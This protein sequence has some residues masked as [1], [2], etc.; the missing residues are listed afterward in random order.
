MRI[1]IGHIKSR[2]DL[3][4]VSMKDNSKTKIKLTTKKKI[5]YF[6]LMIALTAIIALFT[7]EI[8]VR[9]FIPQQE[10]MRWFLSDEKYG[11]VLKKNFHQRYHYLG[12]NFIMDVKTNSLG[13]RDKEYDLSRT[14][15]KRILLLGDS[16]VFGHGVNI[17]DRFDRSCLID[18]AKV[19]W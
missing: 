19:F 3:K 7:L 17:E 1:V 18:Q 16:F 14:D 9:L 8:V 4:G 6:L 13:L 2:K 15:V 5:F 10:A 11:Y 12:Y